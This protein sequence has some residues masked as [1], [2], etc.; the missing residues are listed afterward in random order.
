MNKYKVIVFDLDNTLVDDNKA[1]KYAISKVAEYLKIPYTDTLGNDFLKFDDQYWRRY[2][3][4]EI[5]IPENTQDLILYVRSNR[6]R[7]FFSSISMNYNTMTFLYDL[8]TQST[9][10]CIEEIEGAKETL[11]I[12]K[13]KGYILFIGTNGIKSV[14]YK[15]LE[16]LQVSSYISDIIC[17][18]D[19]KEDKPNALFY[20]YLLKK[21][22]CTKDQVLFVGDSLTSDILGGMKNGI[23]TC[24][25]NPNH[26]PLPEEY[27]PTME[28]DHLLELTRKL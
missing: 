19:I 20:D 18:E 17:S 11:K 5:L 25:F 7:E 15:K 28:I 4:K 16:K 6:F 13:E 10:G 1:R 27:N 8:Y 23:D 14:I 9:K 2:Q 26:L 3:N 12:L 21:C 24:W 22:N